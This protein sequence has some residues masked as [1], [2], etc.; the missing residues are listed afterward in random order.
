MA[1]KKF[2]SGIDLL[3]QRVVNVAD[4][5]SATDAVTLQQLQA[6][7]KGLTWKAAVRAASTTNV[8][9]SAPGGTID[10]VSLNAGDRVLLKNQATASQNGI[11]VYNGAATPLTRADDATD[12]VGS[13]DNVQTLKAGITTYVTEGTVQPD[14]AW[15]LTTDNPITVGTTNLTFVQLGGGTTYTAGNGIAFN[16]NA[17]SVT[18]ATNGGITV[19]AGGVSVTLQANSGLSLSSTGLAVGA[20]SG[21][22]VSGNTVAI[23]TTKV[24]QKYSATIGDGTTTSVVVTHNLGTRDAHVV[25]YDSASYAEVEVDVVHTSINTV[26][27][28]FAVAPTSGAYRVVV[29]A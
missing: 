5:S 18:P 9:V 19:A 22:T 7:V 12:A 13:P 4:A 3:N 8:T 26:T 1:A 27:I 15:T 24:V 23:D 6:Y 28:N 17:I 16:S 20:G 14:T 10:G 29:F 21:I 2:L 25:I 11:Y